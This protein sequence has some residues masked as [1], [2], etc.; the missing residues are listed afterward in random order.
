MTNWKDDLLCQIFS[1]GYDDLRLL[2]GISYDIDF[3][4]GGCDCLYKDHSINSVLRYVFNWGIDDIDTAINNR[5]KELEALDNT[6]ELS[7]DEISELDALRELYP[8][9]DI[10]M[11]INCLDTNLWIED[12]HKSVLYF[13]YLNSALDEF[14]EMTGFE[15][16]VEKE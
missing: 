16:P 11:W 12:K 14:Y 9:K 6:G 10:K 7:G 4:I 3:V 2:E 1:C 5:V 13:T 15:I 8:R